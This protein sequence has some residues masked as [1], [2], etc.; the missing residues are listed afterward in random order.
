MNLMM[1]E[2]PYRD[3][4][5]KFRMLE[6]YRKNNYRVR[7]SQ[8]HNNFHLSPTKVE[9]NLREDGFIIEPEKPTEGNLKDNWHVMKRDPFNPEH[10]KVYGKTIKVGIKRGAHDKAVKKEQDRIMEQAKQ[11]RPIV[12]MNH[13]PNCIINFPFGTGINCPKCGGKGVMA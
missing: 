6:L 7:A 10:D 11:E 2:N 1:L 9:S 4:T 5:H 12:G 8:T 13:C 3:G